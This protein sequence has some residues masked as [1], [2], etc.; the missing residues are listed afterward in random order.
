MLPP[1]LTA[2]QRKQ[3]KQQAFALKPVV[4]LGQKG[5]S[6]AVLAEI[7]QALE[8]H[9]LIKVKLTGFER[10]EYADAIARITEHCR[11]QAIARVGRILT[12]YREPT[13]AD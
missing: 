3:L 9:A 12:L 6:P 4:L 11:A 1:P 13:N 8:A 5:L 7:D 10:S 2:R